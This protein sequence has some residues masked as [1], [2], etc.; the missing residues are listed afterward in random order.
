MLSAAAGLTRRGH[1]ITL[2]AQPGSA[3]ASRALEGGLSP[4]T[5]RLRGDFDPIVIGRL[6]RLLRRRRIEMVCGNM[7]KEIRLAGV[8]SRLAKIPLIRRRGSDMRYPN[9]WRHRLVDRHLVRLIVVN[10]RA[11]R[12]TLLQG[13]P[14]LSP[15]KLRLIYNGIP[16]ASEDQPVDREQVLSEFGL[17]SSSPVLSAVGLLKARKGHEVLFRALPTVLAEF[18]EVSLLVVG[19]GPIREKLERRVSQ[20][21][22]SGS[23]RF[24]GFRSDVLRLMR[25]IDILVLPSQNEGF[26]YVLAEAMS[27]GKPVVATRISS[28]PEVVGE[29]A[30]LLVPPGDASALADAILQ[31]LRDPHRAQQMGRAGRRR[32]RELFDVE[33]M[34]D[35][36]ERLFDQ[37]ISGKLSGDPPSGYSS[38]TRP[39]RYGGSCSPRKKASGYRAC[40]AGV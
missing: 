18:P 5:I 12:N 24:T 29:E 30:G 39:G 16:L 1:H 36:I 32:V 14:W 21:G 26:G 6:Y 20:L 2:V 19:A 23:V 7:G 8:A 37:V 38:C 40:C 3:L 10:S 31:L 33:R 13:N 28:I 15:D 27:V 4:E 9:K 11:T 25:A 22:L 17:Q 34:L 35:E